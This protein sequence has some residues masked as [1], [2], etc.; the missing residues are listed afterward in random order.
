MIS[1]TYRRS[2]WTWRCRDGGVDLSILGS[3]VV[4]ES[5]HGLGDALKSGLHT[6]HQDLD[7]VKLLRELG[8]R[9]R[10]QSPA[11]QAGGEQ[12]LSIAQSIAKS[13]N[14]IPPS[15]TSNIFLNTINTAM[16]DS[17]A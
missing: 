13:I 12:S 11:G 2:S 16:I 3:E 14:S 6:I 17:E 15:K 7:L 9:A 8:L 10:G 4:G 1:Q 5:L